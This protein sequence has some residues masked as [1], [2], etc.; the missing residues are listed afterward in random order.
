[1][2]GEDNDYLAIDDIIRFE[3]CDHIVLYPLTIVHD[4]VPEPAEIF[5]VKLERAP[6][7]G[8]NIDFKMDY[9]SANVT[10]RAHN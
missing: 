10:I 8:T 9:E 4:D 7:H 1:M 3:S 2:A 6:D 5:T